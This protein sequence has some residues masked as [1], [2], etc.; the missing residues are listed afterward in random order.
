MPYKSIKASTR[1]HY[2][3]LMISSNVMKPFLSTIQT[4]SKGN[5][6]STC[7]NRLLLNSSNNKCKAATHTRL[8]TFLKTLSSRKSNPSKGSYKT[9][10]KEANSPNTSKSCMIKTRTTLCN[11]TSRHLISKRSSNSLFSS[12][13]RLKYAPR[14]RLLDGV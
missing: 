10:F 7:R 8:V 2:P 9:V 5:T 3:Q 6:E 4:K 13:K 1:S 11:K 14:Y 12:M